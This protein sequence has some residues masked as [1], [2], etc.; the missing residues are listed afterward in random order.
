MS[1]SVSESVISAIITD[2][3]QVDDMAFKQAKDMHTRYDPEL[4][5]GQRQRLNEENVRAEIALKDSSRFLR[6]PRMV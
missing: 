1:I 3:R 4:S 6:Y 2:Y 5:E